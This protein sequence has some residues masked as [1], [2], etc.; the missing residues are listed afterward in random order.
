[1][2]ISPSV[3][4]AS[5]ATVIAFLGALHLYYTLASDKFSPRDPDLK[6]RLEAVSPILTSQTTMWKAWVGFNV[7]HS[8]GALLFGAVYGY[9]SI[10][11]WRVLVASPFLL[12]TGVAFL[13]TY[14]VLG[15]VYWFRVPFR[16]IALALLL[17]LA[18]VIV[19]LAYS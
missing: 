1:M 2:L 19:A 7:S 13:A 16:G 11:R 5:S 3:L 4:I 14:L 9:L 17:Y 10:F 18:G 8:L 15:K 6:N 12:I